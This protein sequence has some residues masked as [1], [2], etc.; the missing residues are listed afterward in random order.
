MN[1][2]NSSEPSKGVLPFFR[3]LSVRRH[4]QTESDTSSQKDRSD[5]SLI[6][7]QT[8]PDKH[9]STPPSISVVLSSAGLQARN[10][11]PGQPGLP[12]LSPSAG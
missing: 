9:P 6:S 7:V 12:N 3:R 8:T 1:V 11:R 5:F 4:V 10:A 2:Q